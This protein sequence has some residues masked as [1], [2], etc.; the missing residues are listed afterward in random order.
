MREDT[1]TD[2]VYCPTCEGSETD[3]GAAFE[4]DYE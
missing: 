4:G 1:V 3:P 2:E